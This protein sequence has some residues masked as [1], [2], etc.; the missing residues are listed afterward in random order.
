MTQ[1]HIAHIRKSRENMD[2]TYAEIGELTGTSHTQVQRWMDG[3]AEP[4]GVQKTILDGL[5]RWSMRDDI[6]GK[7]VLLNLLEKGRHDVV[8]RKL[9][10]PNG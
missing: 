10:C 4:S 8:M 7:H 1:D 3:E 9:I 2:L 6:G 5:H